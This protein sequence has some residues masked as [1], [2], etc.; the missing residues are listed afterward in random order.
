MR[1][2]DARGRRVRG[3]EGERPREVQFVVGDSEKNILI[4]LKTYIDSNLEQT[5]YFIT[6]YTQ[7]PEEG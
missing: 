5:T 6:N 4:D 7:R 2:H 1:E 3:T